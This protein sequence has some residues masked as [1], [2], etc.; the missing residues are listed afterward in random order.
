VQTIILLYEA[1]LNRN[2]NYDWDGVNFWIDGYEGGTSYQTISRSFLNSPEFEQ[3]FG[4]PLNANQQNYLSNDEF[5][6]T[7]YLNVLDRSGDP[8]GLQYWNSVLQGNG[9]RE[10]VLLNCMRSLCPIEI[11]GSSRLTGSGLA[12]LRARQGVPGELISEDVAA[13]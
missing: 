11:F 10:S 1:A 7:M 13:A 2:G 12:C 4:E 9:N 8:S 6:N 5:V 3:K